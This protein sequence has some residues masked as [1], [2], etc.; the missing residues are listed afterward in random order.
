MLLKKKKRMNNRVK[1]S[2]SCLYD[3]I[4]LP[5]D[6]NI[7][8]E[9][10]IADNEITTFLNTWYYKWKNKLNLECLVLDGK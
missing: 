6:Y 8:Q 2:H 5:P 1:I 10:K 4:T 3:S 9:Y 7:Y